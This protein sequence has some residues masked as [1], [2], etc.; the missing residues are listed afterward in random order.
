MEFKYFYYPGGKW[1]ICLK[2]DKVKWEKIL[3]LIIISKIASTIDTTFK[4]NNGVKLLWKMNKKV[5]IKIVKS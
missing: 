2:Q 4:R 5:K 1:E 3:Q